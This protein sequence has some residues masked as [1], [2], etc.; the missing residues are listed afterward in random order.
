M[1]IRK[2]LG[3]E[4]VSHKRNEIGAHFINTATEKEGH[5]AESLLSRM[6]AESASGSWNREI[7]LL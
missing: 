2:R 6:M 3:T 7:I 1:A 5:W 4:R